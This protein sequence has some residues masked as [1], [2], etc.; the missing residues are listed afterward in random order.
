MQNLGKKCP[1]IF[2]YTVLTVIIQI[3]NKQL[4]VA[5]GHIL[6]QVNY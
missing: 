2:A 6:K 5:A 1:K 4:F 3:V